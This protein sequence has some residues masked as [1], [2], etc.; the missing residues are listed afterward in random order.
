[1]NIPIL[2][3]LFIFILLTLGQQSFAQSIN[4]ANLQR[5]LIENPLI[6]KNFP[7]QDKNSSEEK[8]I[9]E[10]QSVA[11][12]DNNLQLDLSQAS[13]Q[14]DQREVNEKSMLMRYFYALIGKDLNIYG[15]NEFNQPQ[16]DSLLFFNTIGKNYQ[17]APGDTIQITITGLSPSNE[18]YQVMNDGTITLENVY[19]LN[20]NNLNLN[21]VRILV[22]DKIQLDDASAE[23]FVRLN[24]ARLVTV[25]I[26]GNVKSPRT[27]A[28]PAYTPLSRVIAFSGGI[29]DS[30]SLRNIS[31]SQ[32]GEATQTVDFYSFLQNPSSE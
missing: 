3:N 5:L 25:Q 6:S 16:D 30:G 20:V 8:L 18:N 15:S 1:M 9:S 32:I 22:L 4:D 2:R 31:L 21:Q 11:N 17:L 26:S 13:D 10:K 23:V 29:S 7:Q 24:N 19:P 12:T 27:I 14:S 28:V